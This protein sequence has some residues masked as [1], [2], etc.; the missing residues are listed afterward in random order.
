MQDKAEKVRRLQMRHVLFTKPE[1]PKA[2]KDV[3]IFYNPNN[4]D[5]N[6][7]FSKLSFSLDA[8]KNNLRIIN[9]YE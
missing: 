1:I 7:R 6:K 5:L 8:S 4:T 3:T 9:K 2:G